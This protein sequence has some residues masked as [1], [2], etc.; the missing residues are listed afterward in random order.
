MCKME[1]TA[2]EEGMEGGGGESIDL[3]LHGRKNVG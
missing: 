3:C 2:E 1:H